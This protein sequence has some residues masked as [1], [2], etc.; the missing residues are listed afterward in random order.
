MKNLVVVMLLWCSLFFTLQHWKVKAH[1][2][3][4]Q[5]L[6][7]IQ[8]PPQFHATIAWTQADS[9]DGE[10]QEACVE[11][12]KCPKPNVGIAKTPQETDQ[13]W[14]PQDRA[15]ASETA[16]TAAGDL[17]PQDSEW[18]TPL[19]IQSLFGEG[20]GLVQNQRAFSVN[21]Q[22]NRPLNTQYK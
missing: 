3:P 9:R 14:E 4:S 11:D 13:Q 15:G 12:Q 17:S 2:C 7:Q 10:A 8:P 18:H 22:S 16:A 20:L 6:K 1:L 19:C 21:Y 5:G